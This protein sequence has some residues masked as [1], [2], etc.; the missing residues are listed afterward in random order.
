MKNVD[1]PAHLEVVISFYC[2]GYVAIDVINQL[3]L[4]VYRFFYPFD[5]PPLLEH[6]IKDAYDAC[7]QRHPYVSVLL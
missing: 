4:S 3:E 1:C 5:I 6:H 2:I 7:P